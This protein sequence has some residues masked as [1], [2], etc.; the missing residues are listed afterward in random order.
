M[1]IRLGKNQPIISKYIVYLCIEKTPKQ[2]EEHYNNYLRPDIN[3]DPWT[4]EEDVLLM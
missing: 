1:G 4:Y 3:K 2:I